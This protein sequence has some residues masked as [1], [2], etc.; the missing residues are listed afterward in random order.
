MISLSAM[1]ATICL[2]A[3]AALI[4]LGLR[5]GEV[6]PGKPHRTLAQQWAH[7]TRRPAGRD[8]RRRDLVWAAAAVAGFLTYLATHW[9][10]TLVLVPLAVVFGPRLMGVAPQNN[11]PLMEALDRWVRAIAAILPQGLDITQAIRNSRGRAPELLADEVNLLVRRMDAGVSPED[12]LQMMADSLD[13]AEADAVIASL[14][15]ALRRTRGASDNLKAIANGLQDR[16]K[17]LRA[18]EAE[19]TKPR[20]EARNITL[21]ST[22]LLVGTATLARATFASLA[23]PPGQILMIGCAAVYLVGATWMYRMTIP[24]K[25]ARILIKPRSAR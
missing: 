10:A 18:V 14:K 24:R 17:V 20:V 15:L 4:V 8:G 25:R 13:D 3:G 2:L 21:V 9:I 12:A 22:I 1:M 19:R 6:Q 5:P 16:M 11:L 7:T 23:T